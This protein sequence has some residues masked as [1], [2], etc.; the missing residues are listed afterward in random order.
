MR[1]ANAAAVANRFLKSA[2][3]PLVTDQYEAWSEGAPFTSPALGRPLLLRV[4]RKIRVPDARLIFNLY[5]RL[6][7]CSLG[8]PLPEGG[9]YKGFREA[10]RLL[11]RV[12]PRLIH[13]PGLVDQIVGELR[14]G[15][16]EAT[17]LLHR[18]DKGGASPRIY[19][20]AA[21]RIVPGLESLLSALEIGSDMKFLPGVGHFPGLK[22][23]TRGVP[24]TGAVPAIVQGFVTPEEQALPKKARQNTED[25][26]TLYREATEAHAQQLDLLNRGKGL[27]ADIG[28]KVVRHDLGEKNTTTSG[29]TIL[30]G[31]LKGLKRVREKLQESGE[32]VGSLLDLVRAT[33]IVDR[34]E[35]VQTVLDKLRAKGVKVARSPK[36]RFAN[37][38]EAGYRDLMFNLRYP[39]GHIGELQVNLRPMMDAKAMGHKFYERV[40]EIEARKKA[41]NDRSLTPEEQRTVNE[42]SALQKELY[43]EAWRAIVGGGSG[44]VKLAK[45]MSDETLYFEYNDRPAFVRWLEV[46][47][48]VSPGGRE[49]PMYD[50]KKFYDEA[51]PISRDEFV[52]RTRRNRRPLNAADGA[53]RAVLPESPWS[54]FKH[55]PGAILVPLSKLTPIRA[56]PSG[57]EHAHEHMARSYYDNGPRRD[58]I[59]VVDNG[60]GTYRVYDGNST[61]AVATE[62]GWASIPVMVVTP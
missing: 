53:N 60:N 42:A 21:L 61:F 16:S 41:E 24:E 54:Y 51:V 35:E 48:V 8:A 44:G 33:V 55:L 19:Q 13:D 17:S 9:F 11:T 28:G 10:L 62:A 47:V 30:I 52:Q 40:R 4:N 18:I 32:G 37:P 27:D 59:S 31:G 2:H 58:P 50:H 20:S 29:P 49:V 6:Y 14:G 38:T 26:D 57:I 15:V 23:D 1:E 7:E 56:R 43:G 22:L 12:V 25:L 34:L 3:D 5:D 39:N 46:P 45:T 36:N